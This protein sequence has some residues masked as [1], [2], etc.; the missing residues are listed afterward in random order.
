MSEAR[1]N[2]FANKITFALNISRTNTNFM[3]HVQNLVR[4]LI[5]L[6]SNEAKVQKIEPSSH[7]LSFEFLIPDMADAKC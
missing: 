4:Q 2:D 6:S 5:Q 3:R 1:K 7:E